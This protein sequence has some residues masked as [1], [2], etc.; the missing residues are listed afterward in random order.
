MNPHRGEQTAVVFCSFLAR[1][2]ARARLFVP[3]IGLCLA[4]PSV[5][6]L[7]NAPV[8]ALALAG[9]VGYGIGRHFVDAN[10]MPILC[11]VVDSRYRATSWGISTF[12]SCV[13]GA[14]GIYAGGILRDA[15]VDVS[16]VFQFA[17]ANLVVG[18][19]LVF[20]LRRYAS[21]APKPAAD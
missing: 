4:A 19:F 16:R 17:A 9:L 12:F 1:V 7:A 18:A 10:T 13:V 6:L 5:L 20:H 14:A 2:Q 8:L 15:H 11:L 3:V 21:A